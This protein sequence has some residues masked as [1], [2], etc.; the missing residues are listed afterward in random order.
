MSAYL[1]RA[2][3]PFDRE[4]I[5]QHRYQMFEEAGTVPD[6]LDTAAEPFE[7]WLAAKL[8]EGSYFGFIAEKEH[9]QP[10]AG[11]GLMAVDWPPHPLHPTDSRRGY[12]LNLYVE[13]KHRGQGL[14]SQLMANAENAF[15][16]RG[17]SYAILHPTAMAAPIYEKMGWVK[18]S[19]MG[20]LMPL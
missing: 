7:D 2:I 9:Q 11:I 3:D 1:I 5:C 4:I 18:T 10:V 16:D 14:S 17:I 20:K 19:E 15:K 13:K 8:S 12:I 6:I